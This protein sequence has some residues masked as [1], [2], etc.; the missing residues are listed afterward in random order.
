MKPF[1]RSR[2]PV[3]LLVCL[4][5][6]LGAGLC[7]S[8]AGVGD[9]IA[10]DVQ[11]VGDGE[12]VLSTL[13]TCS[14]DGASCE[15][16][17]VDWAAETAMLT[18]VAHSGYRFDH[19]EDP[20]ADAGLTGNKLCFDPA[21]NR[22]PTIEV[23]LLDGP[24][25]PQHTYQFRKV[26]RAVFVAIPPP[27]GD[28][29]AVSMNAGQPR[30]FVKVIY[31]PFGGRIII[32]GDQAAAVPADSVDGTMTAI[33]S[34]SSKP[35][36]LPAAPTAASERVIAAVQPMDGVAF[37]DGSL[38]VGGR[39]RG[40][41]PGAWLARFAPDDSLSWQVTLG[42]DAQQILEM[43]PD[44]AGGVWVFGTRTGAAGRFVASITGTGTVSSVT[45]LASASFPSD[46]VPVG[47]GWALA[48]SQFLNPGRDSNIV[49]A[50]A[51]GA[52]RWQKHV[53][54]GIADV[55]GL[56]A[57]ADGGLLAFGGFGTDVANG[58]TW[59]ARFAADGTLQW[60]K[61][62][63]TVSISSIYATATGFRAVG[64]GGG[65]VVMDLDTNG[66]VLDARRFVDSG[67]TGPGA[68]AG[69]PTADGGVAMA[70][71]SSPRMVAMVTSPDLAIT[72]CADQSLGTDL[73]IA[74]IVVA[75]GTAT[76]TDGAVV[77]SSLP[78]YVPVPSAATITTD[79]PGAADLCSN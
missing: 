29:W 34:P 48:M 51:S 10:L 79:M 66:A 5:P 41:A 30:S 56:T 16:T 35:G 57:L 37:G 1:A 60:Q 12:V 59:L 52:V 55:R 14:G 6:L 23:P 68:M 17:F 71:T 15:W 21:Q 77:L 62:Y 9:G 63:T 13:D 2:V 19:W 74:S 36:V 39:K 76:I 43:T 54:G 78:A 72:G 28:W 61:T 22:S 3:R 40:P 70:G 53:S 49:V 20:A 27:T 33:E 65:M 4:L 69:F 25:D 7:D 42:S 26:C 64:G 45:N 8:D 46:I 11:I 24:T 75:D 67:T 44:G 18:A 31:L 73:D 58:K 38:M 50:D 32:F 47:G